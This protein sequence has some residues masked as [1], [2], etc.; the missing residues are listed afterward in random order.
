M[1]EREERSLKNV[2]IARFIRS[3]PSV[4]RPPARPEIAA[5]A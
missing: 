2:V 1:Q 3:N 4:G 5:S